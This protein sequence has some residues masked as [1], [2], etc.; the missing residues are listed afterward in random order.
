L[1]ATSNI[2]AD[3]TQIVNARA[4]ENL[5]VGVLKFKTGQPNSGYDFFRA[6]HRALLP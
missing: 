5:E 1:R 4:W 2:L 3:L 6:F